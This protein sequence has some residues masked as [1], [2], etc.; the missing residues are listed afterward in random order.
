[1]DF[2]LNEKQR[3]FFKEA[4]EN[5]NLFITGSAGVGKSYLVNEIVK[6]KKKNNKKVV[7]CATTGVAARSINGYTVHHQ[8]HIDVTTLTVNKPNDWIKDVDLIVI[9]EISMMPFHLFNIVGK[10][11]KEKNPNCQL[12][13]I[14]D[15]F[16]L[17]PVITDKDKAI[18]R[19]RGY[20]DIKP[21]EFHAFHSK[22]WKEFNFKTCTLTQ[23]MRQDDQKFSTALYNLSRGNLQ[24]EDR[25]YF[26]IAQNNS[27]IKDDDSICLCCTNKK[28][29]LINEEKL[30][31]LNGQ[32][33]K[34]N[35]SYWGKYDSDA[36]PK[37]LEIKIGAK[38]M[39]TVNTKEYCN[40]DIGYVKDID[41]DIITITLL[42]GS[43]IE[44]E[45]YEF[46]TF[47]YD[48]GKTKIIG[49]ITQFPI[50]LAWAITV[51]KSQGQTFNKVNFLYDNGFFEGCEENLTLLYVG[52][53]RAK[54]VDRLYLRFTSYVPAFNNVSVNEFYEGKFE[55]YKKTW[56]RVDTIGF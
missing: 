7:I 30:N 17:P 4:M 28:V 11:I 19:K 22:Y 26:R 37:V 5:K 36:A 27:F 12:I 34:F 33:K 56:E 18:I 14:G 23:A 55:T 24:P 8:F 25:E 51:H 41:E 32:L 42:N 20:S 43:E 38:V 3:E 13:L 49:N 29:N 9:D 45:R 47:I 2:N 53:S 44:V 6:E 1:M 54:S 52:M 10:E 39:M 46:K 48:E 21:N 40:G 16:Q 50:K 15:F 35:A 31:N